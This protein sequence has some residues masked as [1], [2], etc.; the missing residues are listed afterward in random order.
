MEPDFTDQDTTNNWARLISYGYQSAF[1]VR[2]FFEPFVFS[3]A[4]AVLLTY[5]TLARSPATHRVS[6]VEIM[7]N[8]PAICT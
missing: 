7:M 4:T 8:C 1:T 3:N 5:L 6:W 2:G